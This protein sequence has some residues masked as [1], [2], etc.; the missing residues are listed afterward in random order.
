M[1]AL[2]VDDSKLVRQIELAVFAKIGGVEVDEAEDGADALEKLT[3]N[4]YDIVLLDWMMPKMTG[5]QLLREIRGANGPNKDTPVLMVTA[6]AERSKILTMIPLKINGYVTKPFTTE[7]LQEKIKAII[8]KKK[9][10]LG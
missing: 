5:E 9:I 1:K 4:K 8:G 2:V 3:K 10:V 6:E 7:L